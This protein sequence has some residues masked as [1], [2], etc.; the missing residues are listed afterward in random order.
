MERKL[1]MLNAVDALINAHDVLNGRRLALLTNPSGVDRTL[2]STAD[3]LAAC[4]RLTMLFGPEHGIRGDA[5]AGE[6]AGDMT[7]PV[8]NLPVRSLYGSSR[9]I[10]EEAFD[11]FDVL[12][13]DIQDVGARFYTYIYTL[14]YAMEDCARHDKPVV[15]MDRINPLGG[16]HVEGL[17]LKPSLAS[18]IGLYPMPARYGLTVGEFATF[19]N[20]TKGIHCDLTVLPCQGLDRQMDFTATDMLWVPPSPNI[21][22]PDTAL[23]YIGTCLFEGTNVSEGRGTTHPFEM[24]GAPFVDAIRLTAEMESLQLPGTAWRPVHFV[25]AFSKFQGE[26]CHG[27]QLYITD[28][29]Q[30]NAFETGLALV[31]AI[32]RLCPEFQFLPTNCFNRLLGDDSYRL[33]KEDLQDIC[34]RA[35]QESRLFREESRPFW[36]YR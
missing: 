16:T 23:A 32:R 10:P 29:E 4:Y 13:Y 5:Q 36:L 2:K 25:P 3:R 22:T 19:I 27:V 11:Q 14:A 26:L 15:V 17:R 28:R 35:R 1:R 9:H 6:A 8:L 33:G 31:D 12:L 24:V 7:D 21:P 30:V 20:E 34:E 18:F